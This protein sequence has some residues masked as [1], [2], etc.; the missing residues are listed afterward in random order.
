MRQR[1]TCYTFRAGRNL[2]DKEFRYLRT[3]IVT[4][5]VHRGFD[6][7]LQEMFPFPS[8]LLLT[9]R[10]WAGVSPYTSPYGFAET[11]VFVKQS[12]EPLRCESPMLLVA[13]HISDPSFSRSY[14]CILPSS[15]TEV[16]PIALHYSC[17]PPVSVCGTGILGSTLRR[18]S[19]QPEL[20]NLWPCGSAYT[21]AQVTDLPI[22][23]S[24]SALCT[25]HVQWGGSAILLRLS[26]GPQRWYRNVD[27]LS[28]TYGFRPRLRPD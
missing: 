22:T 5:A 11:C 16:L 14:G 20:T 19:R 1:S 3:V 10:H 28:I 26:F 13:N 12:V 24:T 23:L 2:P 21:S 15:L 6:S 18:F 25:S 27:R 17:R 9:F 8:P 7:K 4:A